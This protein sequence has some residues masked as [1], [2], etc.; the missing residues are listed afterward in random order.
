MGQF[1]FEQLLGTA[2]QGIDRYNIT[3]TVLG[4]AGTIL[5]LSFH[6]TPSGARNPALPLTRTAEERSAGWRIR[7]CGLGL[8]FTAGL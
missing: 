2:L 4:E 3:A 6:V 5:L 8:R 7:P 1:Y